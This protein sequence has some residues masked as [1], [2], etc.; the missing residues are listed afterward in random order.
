MSCILE[1]K[2]LQFSVPQWSDFENL[3]ALR[4]D[5][6]VM[7]YIGVGSLENSVGDIQTEEQVK[8]HIRLAEG[9]FNEYGFAFFCVFEKKTGEFLGQAG[10]FHLGYNLEQPDIEVAYRFLKKYWGKGYATEAAQ[11]LIEW[12]FKEKSLP[13]L[14]ALVHPNNKRSI[15]VLEKVGMHY[16]GDIDYRSHQVPFYEIFNPHDKFPL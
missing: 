13:K 1:T 15:R 14:V 16:M 5:P 7:R 3:L 8:E 10:L 9:Y 4:A 2:R 12:A 11:G 6:E